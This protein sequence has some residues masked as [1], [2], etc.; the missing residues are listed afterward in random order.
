MGA[1][2]VGG[3]VCGR[4]ATANHTR[5]DSKSPAAVSIVASVY[6]HFDFHFI[7]APRA[8]VARASSVRWNQSIS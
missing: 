5:G 3:V 2:T 8:S 1:V 4:E 7:Q 6:S